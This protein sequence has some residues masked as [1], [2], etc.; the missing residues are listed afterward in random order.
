MPR[1]LRQS[2][3]GRYMAM[4]CVTAIMSYAA[5]YYI[6][7]VWRAYQKWRLGPEILID[8][9]IAKRVASLDNIPRIG[10]LDENTGQT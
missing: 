6:P 7:Q 10:E 5:G 1:N 9:D 2:P 4:L 3:T 8:H